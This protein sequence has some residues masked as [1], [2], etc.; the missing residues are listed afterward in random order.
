MAGDEKTKKDIAIYF[1]RLVLNWFLK[2]EFAGV[3]DFN[4]QCC[5]FGLFG[6]PFGMCS[7]YSELLRV[8]RFGD[9]S[10]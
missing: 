6:E 7:K 5:S 3:I 4:I 8:S 1:M 2:F 9:S 10:R